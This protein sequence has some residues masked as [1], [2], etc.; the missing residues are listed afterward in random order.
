MTVLQMLPEVIGT[1]E[2][3]RVVAL[4]K[5]MV[6]HQMVNSC[7]PI[8]FQG[9]FGVHSMLACSSPS[10]LFAAVPASIRFSGAGWRVVES[11]AIVGQSGAGP[12]MTPE[13]E[14]ILMSFSLIFV[15]EA[16]FAVLAFILLF[17]FM[18]TITTQSVAVNAKSVR[19]S[20]QFFFRLE[21]L[22]LLWTAFADKHSMQLVG[23]NALDLTHV[24][25][26]RFPSAYQRSS[27][28]DR[29]LMVGT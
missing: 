26:R 12:R 19:N 16:I 18:C 27:L 9:S 17:L 15:L 3:F 20:L 2:F 21:F 24:S 28:G 29:M 7:L 11:G 23:S 10:K 8:T 25:F 14:G 22:W 4:P 5:F 6:L 13:M 1:E